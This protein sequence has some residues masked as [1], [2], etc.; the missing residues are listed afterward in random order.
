MRSVNFTPNSRLSNSCIGTIAHRNFGVTRSVD[1]CDFITVTGTYHSVLG[2][3]STLLALSC[4]NTR[5]TVPGCGIVNLTGTSLRTG[6]HCVTG[7]VNPRNIHIGTVSTNPVHAL[8]TSNV[9]SF[10]GVLTRYRTIAPVHHAI[11]VRSINGSTTFL[12]SSLSTNVSNRIIRISNNFDV[13]TVGR[14][15]LGWS[16][17]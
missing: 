17:Y 10:H 8:T 14:L 12:Y 6:I 5:H 9:G 3:N 11:A 15:R 16:F 1:S 2:P 4:L 13:T 7:T